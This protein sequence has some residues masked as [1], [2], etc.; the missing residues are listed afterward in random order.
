MLA[1][2]QVD[3]LWRQTGVLRDDVRQSVFPS[4]GAWSD[5]PT[6]N[7]D[8]VSLAV[9]GDPVEFAVLTEREHWVAHAIVDERIVGIEARN[10]ELDTTGLVTETN[11]AAYIEGSQEMRR[12]MRA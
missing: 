3:R 6:A 4:D 11:F 1:R 8:R 2:E 10:W 9:D 12:R 5:D 7:W